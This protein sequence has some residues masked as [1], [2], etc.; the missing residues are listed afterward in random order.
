MKKFDSYILEL[1]EGTL[2]KRTTVNKQ[3]AHII[4]NSFEE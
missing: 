4:R 2:I 1:I 3:H